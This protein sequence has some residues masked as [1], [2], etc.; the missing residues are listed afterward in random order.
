MPPSL[1]SRALALALAASLASASAPFS[2]PPPPP[3]A[4]P[5]L[6]A[7]F[8]WCA[9]APAGAQAY[10]A[11]RRNFTLG[12]LPAA[13]LLHLFA[14]SRYVVYVNG[15]AAARGPCRFDPRSPDYDSIDVTPLLQPGDNALAV[16]VHTIGAGAS[17]FG[18]KSPRTV[19]K[20]TSRRTVAGP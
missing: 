20:I 14:D 16:L 6:Q 2:P 19:A 8:V 13:A 18:G 9:S 1:R 4:G 15:V 12:A 17:G 11:F 7:S 10:V 3:P 5:A